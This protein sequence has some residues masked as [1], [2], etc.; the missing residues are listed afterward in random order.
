MAKKPARPAGKPAP[1]AISRERGAQTIS[2]ERGAQAISR[3]RGAQTISREREAQTIS[4]ERG[5]LDD[6]RVLDL[7]RILAGP[8]SAMILGDLGADVIKVEN[9]EGGDDTRTFGPAFKAGESAYF[10]SANRNKRSILVDLKTEEGQGIV[11]ALAQVSDVVIENYR[12][13]TLEK[14]G[15]GPDAMRERNPRLVTCSAGKA[16]WRNA[17]ATTSSSRQRAG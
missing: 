6:I 10:M 7:S 1:Q 16:H 11:R 3:E 2:R 8:T 14:L 5:A 13:G 12:L 17:P 9:P 15:L 4:R